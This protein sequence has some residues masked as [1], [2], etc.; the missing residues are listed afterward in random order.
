M[1]SNANK[2]GNR[3]DDQ[4]HDRYTWQ[5]CERCLEFATVALVDADSDQVEY[6]GSYYGLFYTD[7]TM[8]KGTMK[9]EVIVHCQKIPNYQLLYKNV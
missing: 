7:P 1:D 5:I 4:R 9:V 8:Y 6:C 2:E 3:P